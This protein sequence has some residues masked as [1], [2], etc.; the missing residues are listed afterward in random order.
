[1]KLAKVIYRLSGIQKIAGDLDCEITE[2]THD[3]RD[4]GSNTLFIAMRGLVSDGHEFIDKALEAGAKAIVFDRSEIIL[5]GNIVSILVNDSRLALP[6]LAA[7]FYEH[8]ESDLNLI[9][10]TGTNGKTTCNYFIQ[11]LLSAGQLKTGRI[12]TTGA[13]LD[14]LEIDLIHTTPESIDLYSILN[15][16]AKAN[17]KVVTLEVSSH[18]LAQHRVDGLVFKTA[19]FTNLT[20][21][22]LDY[23]N[24]FDDYLEAKQLLFT[25]LPS[26]AIAIINSDDPAA[27]K[28]I[29]QSNARVVRYGYGPKANYRITKSILNDRG[30][31]LHI[32]TPNEAF[33]VQVNTIGK[34]NTYN[35][36]AVFT[37]ALEMGCES[38]LIV[39]ASESL[40]AVPGRLEK[41]VNTAPFKVFID[42]A[43]TPDAMQTVLETL[44]EAYP[45]N[46]IITVFGCGG[47][48]DKGK[49][50]IMG[51]I[52]TRLSTFCIITDDN[53]RSES[54]MDIIKEIESG[55]G[56]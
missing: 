16:F 15:T 55:C 49:R 45:S 25:G 44:G 46:R 39:K 56:S 8:P 21:D 50:P 40:P 13:A 14:S 18:A 17:A 33:V 22:H 4:V 34:Y 29:S 53:P 35:F 10:I 9:G 41:M 52:A 37:V 28:I 20:Q 24:T 51:E 32:Q 47:D 38:G 11:H 5:P 6:V 54:P 19:I 27:E 42:Y 30:I 26:H 36:L 1:M 12:G 3:S 2:M 7:N 31:E 48:R 23:H 43:H